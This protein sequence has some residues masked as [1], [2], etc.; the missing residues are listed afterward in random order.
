MD[1]DK[2]IAESIAREYVPCAH[3]SLY[4]LKKLDRKVKIPAEIFTYT[5]GIVSAILLW[6]GISISTGTAGSGTAAAKTFGIATALSGFAGMGANF[7][8]YKKILEARKKQ[9][10]FEIIEL[11]KKICKE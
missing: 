2:I 3:E 10:S 1:T 4:A 9:Y 8:L 6:A 5:L 11:A 7:P